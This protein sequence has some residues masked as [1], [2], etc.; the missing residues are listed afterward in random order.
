MAQDEVEYSEDESNRYQLED[1]HPQASGF[2]FIYFIPR[3][4][5]LTPFV[6]LRDTRLF[7][8]VGI[9]FIH[10]Q[11]VEEEVERKLGYICT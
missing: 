1:L 10:K 2:G 7:P 3:P 11:P 4:C 8:I 6:F 9:T 5:H